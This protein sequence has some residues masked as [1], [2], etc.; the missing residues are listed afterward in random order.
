MRNSNNLWWALVVVIS[1]CSAGAW[2]PGR[3]ARG[4]CC[5]TQPGEP[6]AGV[7]EIVIGLCEA[8]AQQVF[9]A[10]ALEEGLARN[11][12]DSGQLQ[13]VHRLLDAVS[14]WNSRGVGQDIIGPGR[15]AGFEAGRT[16][17]LADYLAFAAISGGEVAVE[18]VR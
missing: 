11:A 7:F 8:K 10:T 17:S 14:A 16:Q 1:C 4:G 9:A 2:I 18:R 15:N 13:Q 6:L 5:L 3:S 12:R